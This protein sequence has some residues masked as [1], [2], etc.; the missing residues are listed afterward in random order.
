MDRRFLS[1]LSILP[2]LTAVVIAFGLVLVPLITTVLPTARTIDPRVI[3]GDQSIA[4]PDS[5]R[6]PVYSVMIIANTTNV[7]VKWPSDTFSQ[8]TFTVRNNGLMPDSYSFTVDPGISRIQC[9]T[10]PDKTDMLMPGEETE[11]ALRLKPPSVPS[12]TTSTTYTIK[13]KCTSN[14]NSAIFDEKSFMAELA[15]PQVELDI[16]K[17]S[18]THPRAG[19]TVYLNVRLS[20]KDDSVSNL[21]F[22]VYSNGEK[23]ASR[24]HISL[25][26]NSTKDLR[27]SITVRQE[28]PLDL[29]G[30]LSL[31]GLN[32]SQRTVSIFVD[33]RPSTVTNYLIPAFIILVILA[34]GGFVIWRFK[35]GKDK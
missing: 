5:S 28:G 4:N 2:G 19:D 6:G 21:S 27:L 17:P 10:A 22:T 29:K 14:T 34:A 26:P 30:V 35:F 11:I 33:E 20:T 12:T 25:E 32:M 15:I 18:T 16:F 13:V 3:S 1:P 23:A 8:I 7:K 9:W 31:G 24:E